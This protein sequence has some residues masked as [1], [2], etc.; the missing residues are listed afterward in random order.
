MLKR[1]ALLSLAVLFSSAAMAG[2]A[3]PSYLTGSWGT[4][5]SLWAGTTQQ[6]QMHFQADGSG[7]MTGS[8]SAPRRVGGVEDGST[9]PR[10]IAGFPFESK[11]D[12]DVLMVRPGW[13]GM[14]VAMAKKKI[15]FLCRHEAAGPV[16]RCNGPDGQPIVMTWHIETIPEE[17]VKE[18]AKYKSPASSHAQ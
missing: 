4:A 15:V 8:S 11:M 3:L 7:I 12:G 10:A 17:V 18:I 5:E 14:E 6:V 2:E 16:L 9:P 13:P 1:T